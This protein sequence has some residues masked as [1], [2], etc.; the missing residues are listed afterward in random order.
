[1]GQACLPFA[2]KMLV[3][4]EKIRRLRSIRVAMLVAA[5]L[6]ASAAFGLHPE[7]SSAPSDQALA[8][9]NATAAVDAPAS[10][11]CLACRAYQNLVF[12]SAAADVAGPQASAIRPVAPSPPAVRVFPILSRDGRSP[13][14][15]S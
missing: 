8:V 13:P 9:R 4:M 15:A 11:D 3:S 7:P 5:C 2:G 1:M 14:I 10:H 6:A 12:A